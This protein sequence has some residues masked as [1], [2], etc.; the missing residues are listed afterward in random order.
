M[1]KY[2]MFDHG[3]VLDGSVVMNLDTIDAENDLVLEP[4]DWGGAQVLRNGV[5]IV[6][7]MNELV[8][9]YQYQIVFHSKNKEEDQLKILLQLQAACQLKKISFPPVLAMAV[10]D[11]ERYTES[12]SSPRTIIIE[13]GIHLAAWGADDFDGKASVRRALE[14]L[15]NITDRS[16]HIVFDDGEP[17]VNTPREEGYQAFLIGEGSERVTLDRALTQVVNDA[18]KNLPPEEQLRRDLIIKIDN[19]LYWREHKNE[20]DRRGY[21]PG[22]FTRLRHYTAFGKNR[23]QELKKTLEKAK[24]EEVITRLQEHLQQ[25]SK[26]DNHSLDTYLLEAVNKHKILFHITETIDLR[27]KHDRT[28]LRDKIQQGPQGHVSNS[29]NSTK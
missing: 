23:A 21:K 17:N 14:K 26:L 27:N 18:K 29:L 19:Y 7:L 15:L 25:H 16:Q 12:S 28:S 13:G 11:P 6:A 9:R 10:F 3:G 20:D 22:L 8:E 1:P 2:L 4:F 24:P 5:Q